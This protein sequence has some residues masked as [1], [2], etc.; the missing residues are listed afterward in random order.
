MVFR[1]SDFDIILG[2]DNFF[3][4]YFIMVALLFN[5][6]IFI[7]G[8]IT[9]SF[10]NC[11]IY[12]LETGG[13]FLKGRSFCPHCR[14]ILEWRDLIPVF[15]FFILKGKCRY[16][17]KKI[18]LQYPIVELATGT[19]FVFI[20]FH[21]LQYINI[22]VNYTVAFFA[23]IYYLVMASFLII[24]FVYDLKH[25]I[26]PDKVVFPAIL[27]SGIWYLVSGIFL[28][29]YTKYEIMNIIYSAVGAAVF[30]LAIVLISRG[31]GMGIGDIKLAFLM[32][33]ILGWPNILAALFLAFFI[34]AIIG[35]GLIIF[36][37][38]GLKSEVPFGPFLIT[39]TFLTMFFGKQL[40]IWYQNLF[41]I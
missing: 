16:C 4:V 7:V 6:L 21:F 30:F 20:V 12:R 17:H 25:Y 29:I 32:G 14:H 1:V 3:N 11:V 40:I 24:I 27:L 31:K 18:S 26:I 36:G 9:G 38:Q 2:F 23:S 19:L 37:K 33:L 39:G 5:I 10:L 28:N 15:S 13:N 8:L 35:L 41:L 22:D 34:G